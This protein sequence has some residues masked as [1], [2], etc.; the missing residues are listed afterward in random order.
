MLFRRN[1]LQFIILY[2]GSF[3][4][5]ILLEGDGFFFGDGTQLLPTGH[6]FLHYKKTLKKEKPV[7]LKTIE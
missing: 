5:E 3:F 7:K 2:E 4:G 6:I 1:I